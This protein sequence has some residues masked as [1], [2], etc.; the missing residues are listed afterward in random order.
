MSTIEKLDQ[1]FGL[2][3]E[4]QKEEEVVGDILLVNYK[5]AMNMIQALSTNEPIDESEKIELISELIGFNLEEKIQEIV[6][7]KEGGIENIDSTE[8]D[9]ATMDFIIGNSKSINTTNEDMDDYEKFL[10][11]NKL[12]DDME[13]LKGEI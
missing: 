9:A 10:D 1:I 4:I 11:E 5:S 3:Q 12:K 7:L 8:T 6:Q 2:I 13:F